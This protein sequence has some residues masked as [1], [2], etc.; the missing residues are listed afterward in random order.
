MNTIIDI[1][2]FLTSLNDSLTSYT[3]GI[4]TV[5]KYSDGTAECWASKSFSEITGT[6]LGTGLYFHVVDTISFPDSLFV[7]TPH[8]EAACTS[9]GTGVFWGSPRNV[10]AGGAQMTVF[11]NNGGA[12]NLYINIQAFGRWK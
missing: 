8:V 7:S 4:W 6:A 11:T 1:H 5:R 12:N 9:W 10:S 2:S 3:D